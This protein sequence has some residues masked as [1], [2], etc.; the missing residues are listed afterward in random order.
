MQSGT[1]QDREGCSSKLKREAAVEEQSAFDLWAGDHK[2][3]RE[4]GIGRGLTPSAGPSCWTA[5]SRGAAES[6]AQC[7]LGDRSSAP[8]SGLE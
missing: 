4:R 6:A 8:S 1:R 3:S 2:C 7:A 5:G